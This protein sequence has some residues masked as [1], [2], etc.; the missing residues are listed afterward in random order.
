MM[1][2]ETDAI[3]ANARP[4]RSPAETVVRFF[5]LAATGCASGFVSTWC[6]GNLNDGIAFRWLPGVLFGLWT[7]GMAWLPR[8]IAARRKVR[9]SWAWLLILFIGIAASYAT[10]VVT[11]IWLYQWLDKPSW[12]SLDQ[13]FLIAIS[14]FVGG[15]VGGTGLVSLWS[16]MFP[17]AESWPMRSM[18]IAC[19][20][21]LGV[22][23]T[24]WDFEWIQDSLLFFVLWQG[25]MAIALA[26]AD[27]YWRRTL[28]AD[29]PN[30]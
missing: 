7:V 12:I 9:R 2:S 24:T 14:G 26:A 17:S 29:P 13:F 28:I 20:A 1:T 23:L 16:L 8:G 25:G 30:E 4:D 19:A 5:L 15:G 22:G 11:S 3:F 6:L 27:T 18:L 21:L 10:A